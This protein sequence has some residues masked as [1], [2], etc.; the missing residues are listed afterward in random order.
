MLLENRV[1]GAELTSLP[2]DVTI[3]DELKADRAQPQQCRA[4]GA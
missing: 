4:T 2:D 1:I 3:T